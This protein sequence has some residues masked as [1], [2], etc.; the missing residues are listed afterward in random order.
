MRFSQR[1]GKKPIKSVLQIELIDDDLKNRLW[2]A[3]LENFF[4][5]LDD[6][7]QKMN[8]CKFIWKEFFKQTI[9]KLPIYSYNDYSFF[10]DYIRKWF[11]NEAEW[12]EIYD[13]IELIAL[14][15]TELNTGFKKEC[16]WALKIE[17]A[18]Y[19]IIDGKVV[20]ITTEEEI[21]AIEEATNYTDK[22]ISV[23]THLKTSLELLSDRKNPNY[24]NSIKE[25]ISAVEAFCKIITNNDKATLG[26]ALK[27]I[28]K[29]YKIHAALK[30]AFTAIYGYTSDSSGIRHALL[31]DD[32]NVTFE[33]AKFMLVCCSAFINYLK[34]KIE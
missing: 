30:N 19:R 3:F 15:D 26:D 12:F 34:T 31:E 13:F 33:D 23:N 25:S 9:D 32:I 14:F 8:I 22:W 29:K 7:E 10:I 20:R 17:L 24:R 21:Q 1:I 2:N 11:F 6:N 5:I 27:E 18:G 4:Y 16:N 28:E